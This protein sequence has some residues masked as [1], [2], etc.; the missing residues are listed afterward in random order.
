MASLTETAHYARKA[1]AFSGIG[2][3]S[4]II[5]R[6]S[7]GILFRWWIAANPP[8]PP[9]PTVAFGVLLAP[10]FPSPAKN[11]ISAYRLETVSGVTPDFGTQAKVFFMP[12]FRANVLGAELA[13]KMAG[14]MGFS[15]PPET[16]DEQIY[17]WSRG[18]TLPGELKINLITGF[19]SLNTVWHQDAELV[20]SRAPSEQDAVRFAKEFLTRLSLLPLDLAAGKTRVEYLKAGA[21]I[22]LPAV[23]Q[24]E[25]NFARVHIFR[26]DV[27]SLPVATERQD[28][29]LAQVI[30]SGASSAKQ[31]I[32]V[33]YKYSPIAIDKSAT[34]PLRSS[35]T[36]WQ[37]LQS[38]EGVIIQV[39][40]GTAE[41]VV[42]N[43]EMAYYDSFTPQEFFQPVYVFKGDNGFKAYVPAIDP[44]WLSK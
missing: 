2:L 36:A 37:Q 8:P 6:F 12:S 22:L 25:A 38:G 20:K 9:T 14:S 15:Q 35:Q 16:T 17:V 3:I 5:L 28:E 10:V 41:A 30:V 43:V 27:N 1:I 4:I 32:G 39:V 44:K 34:Y 21:G 11:S 40:G 23:S 29:A 42:R 24:S 18:G 26:A 31:I 19:F 13:T 7:W 33:E